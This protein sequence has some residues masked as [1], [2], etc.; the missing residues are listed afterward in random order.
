MYITAGFVCYS[1]LA[2]VSDIAMSCG[3]IRGS[4]LMPISLFDSLKGY[5]MKSKKQSITPSEFFAPYLRNVSV[6]AWILAL[7]PIPI[8]LIN[9][10]LYSALVVDATSGNVKSVLICCAVIIGILVISKVFDVVAGGAY[11]R[12][13]EQAMHKCRI[14]MYKVYLSA[15]LSVLM[16]TGHGDAAEMVRDDFNTVAG[17]STGLYPNFFAGAVTVIAYSVFLLLTD[18]I[19]ALL[20]IIVSVWQIVPPLLVSRFMQQNYDACRN[21]EAEVSDMMLEY[22]NGFTEAKMYGLGNWCIEKLKKLH[23]DYLK[24]GN[25]SEITAV[26]EGILDD[27]IKNLLTYGTYALVG[28]LILTGHTTLET[29]AAAIALSGGLY[30]SMSR[31]FSSITSFALVKTAEKRME[32]LFVNDSDAETVYPESAS[33]AEFRGVSLKLGEKTIYD[34]ADFAIDFNGLIVIRGENGIGKSTLFSLICGMLLPDTGCVRLGGVDPSKLEKN[35]FPNK[36]FYLPQEDASFTMTASEM[37]NQIHTQTDSVFRYAKKLGLTEEILN[38]PINTLSGGERK[39]V[40][41]S[42]AFAISPALMLLDEPTNSLDAAG[43]ETLTELLKNFTELGNAV[44]ITHD[45]ELINAANHVYL[46][47]EGGVMLEK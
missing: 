11:Q 8:G 15:P 5:F 19:C 21:I 38:R 6:A 43:R 35:T 3:I 37:Y 25:R 36:I 2:V 45:S 41:L 47:T 7:I 39:K 16:R 14:A 24:I 26:A 29:G 12:A 13:L 42:L 4:F 22:Y 46:V 17:K 1:F 44:I 20:L 40:Y 32:V 28:L 10:K 31:I 23:T 9:A 33:S 18:P 30:S 34:K 27:L